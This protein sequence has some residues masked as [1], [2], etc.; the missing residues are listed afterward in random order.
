MLD[1]A[2][3][4][5]LVFIRQHGH[6]HAAAVEGLDDGRDAL[7][8]MGALDQ[9]LVVCGLEFGEAGVDVGARRAGGHA[10]L[11]QTAHA[12]AHA[13]AHVVLV[14]KRE[15]VPPHGRID[16]ARQVSQGVQ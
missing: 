12:V 15:P 2:D 4:R 5:R 13:A 10:L 14:Q 1:Q 16:R 11:D 3:G 8:G 7:I 9:V 6:A